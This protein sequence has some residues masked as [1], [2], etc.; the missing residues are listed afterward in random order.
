M[1]GF[2]L[3]FVLPVS[4]L[5][6]GIPLGRKRCV[7]ACRRPY[8]SE[9]CF[10]EIRKQDCVMCFKTECAQRISLTC[11]LIEFCDPGK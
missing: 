4:K 2:G 9:L 8:V 1:G 11:N 5:E 10:A 3:G 6:A 7:A